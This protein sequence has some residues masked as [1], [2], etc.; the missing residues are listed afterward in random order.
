MRT[1]SMALAIA[2]P[3]LLWGGDPGEDLLQAARKSDLAKVKAL[4]DQG[5]DVNSKSAYGSTALFFAAD[6]GNT[7]MVALLLERGA[8]PNVKDTFYGATALTWAASKGHAEIARML[9]AKGAEGVDQL[10]PGAVEQGSKEMLKIALDTGKVKP[11]TL[12]FA[13]SMALKAKKDDLAEM[14][15]AAGAK[16]PA[17]APPVPVEVPA[18]KLATFTGR[19]Q[20]G[21]GGTEMEFVVALKDGKLTL[22]NPQEGKP[23][24]LIPSG[25][26]RFTMTEMGGADIEF[27]TDAMEIS[28]Q[29]FT[30]T[31]TR[32]VSK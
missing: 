12:N 13:L 23:F 11:S 29:G 24:T 26:S 31:F 3:L 20:G 30:M 17:A 4:L 14:L 5:T 1:Y 6:R 25:A 21:R 19:Y 18:D 16:P 9:L 8:N 15:K 27:K 10:V 7:Q 32:M 28:R 2:V 22:S